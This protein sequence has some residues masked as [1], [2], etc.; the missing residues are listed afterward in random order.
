M[1]EKFQEL[2][3]VPKWKGKQRRIGL[4]GGIA[5][6]KSSV[7]IFLKEIKGLP[8]LDA[9]VLSR[10]VLAPNTMFSK[11]I[12]ERYK[13]QITTG[14]KEIINRKSLA[15]IIFSNKEERIWIENLLH[16]IIYKNLLK[17][18]ENY[19]K[20]PTVILI[21]PLLFEANFT[22]ICNEIWMVNCTEKQQYERLMKRDCLTKK[23]AKKRIKA[24]WPLEKKR[25]LA[26]VIIDNS[27]DP[28]KWMNQI[29][30][31]LEKN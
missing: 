29:N 19:K 16:P 25:R 22:S 28:D 14:N 8:I 20:S 11:T 9:D 7:G 10:E 6:G 1:T 5:S 4:T 17:E 30:L 12:I 23:E 26:D 13:N 15:K 3:E 2:M 27:K 21:I 31:L 18:I 24:Q